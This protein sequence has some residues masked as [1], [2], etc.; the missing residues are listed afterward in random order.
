M[1]EELWIGPWHLDP[2]GTGE[3]FDINKFMED[4]ESGRYDGREPGRIDRQSPWYQQLKADVENGVYNKSRFVEEDSVFHDWLEDLLDCNPD[5]ANMP[6]SY[7]RNLFL[8]SNIWIVKAMLV[9][10]QL[11]EQMWMTADGIVSSLMWKPSC[12]WRD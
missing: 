3:N 2:Y 8:T 11:P 5:Q 4:A 9:A 6:L 1:G 12:G 10:G 7:W